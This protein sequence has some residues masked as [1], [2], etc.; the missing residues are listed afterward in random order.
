ML[1]FSITLVSFSYSIFLY[2]YQ[3]QIWILWWS[4]FINIVTLL[5]LIVI[6]KFYHTVLSI[7]IIWKKGINCCDRLQL[8]SCQRKMYLWHTAI[9]TF[10]NS[11]NQ[12]RHTYQNCRMKSFWSVSVFSWLYAQV[13]GKI[14]NFWNIMKQTFM[15]CV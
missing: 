3:G 1:L 8:H 7:I 9:S 12:R 6:H 2:I 4:L 14:H 5:I 15:K 13:G 10:S 11:L